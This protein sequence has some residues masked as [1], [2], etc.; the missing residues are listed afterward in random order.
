MGDAV[1]I[2]ELEDA[3]VGIAA[4]Y[5]VRQGISYQSWREVGVPASV[6]ARAGISRS[7]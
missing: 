7:R 2:E 5:S 3:F 1:D 6:L 4:S